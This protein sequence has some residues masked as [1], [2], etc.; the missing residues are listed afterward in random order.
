[1][2]QPVDKKDLK[3]L[4]LGLVFQQ[5][6]PC[7]SPTSGTIFGGYLACFQPFARHS[8][9]GTHPKDFHFFQFAKIWLKNELHFLG[10][11][12]SPTPN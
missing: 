11:L 1:L 4:G 5:K 8:S 9:L 10:F 3:N 2:G 7:S 6:R 12:D